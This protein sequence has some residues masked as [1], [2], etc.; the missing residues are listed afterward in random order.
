[1]VGVERLKRVGAAAAA[2]TLAACGGALAV[3]GSVERSIG[4][5][6]YHDILTE[7]PAMLLRYEYA[8]YTTR[9][10]SST[11]YIET[12]W[13]SRAP[14]DDEAAAGADFARTRFVVR[15]RRAAAAFYSVAITAENQVHMGAPADSVPI[16]EGVGI[17]GWTTLPA[18]PMFQT[19]VEE[20]MT[21]IELKV[22][23]GLRTHGPIR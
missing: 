16:Q 7:V 8:I 14:F 1:M 20:I 4:R 9:E 18:T 11:V 12:D 15:A 13:R 23:A 17:D 5:A 19:Y 2:L 6:T 21:E 10:T 22:D 3:R